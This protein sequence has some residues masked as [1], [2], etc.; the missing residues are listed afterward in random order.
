MNPNRQN[1]FS[2]AVSG[3]DMR[4]SKFPVGFDIKTSFNAGKLVPLDWIEVLPGDT[5]DINGRFVIRGATPLYPV[6]DNAFY[7][8]YAFFVPNRQ[9]DTDWEATFGQNDKDYWTLQDPPPVPQ[10]NFA[11]PGGVVSVGSV[12]DYLGIP[13]TKTS[14]AVANVNAL[15]FRA[16]AKIWNDWFRDENFQNP[17]QITF[18]STSKSAMSNLNGAVDNYYV[19]SASY[20]GMLCPVNKIHDYFTSALPAPQKGEPVSIPLGEFAPV[21]NAGT[22]TNTGVL[23]PT[24]NA[25]YL[26]NSSGEGAGHLGGTLGGIGK[27][28]IPNTPA[29]PGQSAVGSV[30][31]VWGND[32]PSDSPVE[33]YHSLQADLSEAASATINQLR[34][35]FQTQKY[36][37]RLARGGSRYIEYLKSMFGVTSS[38]YRLQRSEYLGGHRFPI[39]QHQVAQTSS[40][41]KEADTPL[42]DT[43]AFSLSNGEG[44]FVHKSFEEHGILMF[45]GCVRTMHT[46]QQGIAREFFRKTAL[47]YYN[48]LFANLGEQP[49]KNAQIYYNPA[50]SL[51]G[52]VPSVNDEVFGYQEAWAEYRY[53]PSRTSGYMR[54]GVTGSLDFWHYGDK[55]DNLPVL[56]SD[57]IS[58]TPKNIDRTLAVS[59]DNTHQFW[60]D[61]YFYGSS[62]RVM[63]VYSIPGLIDHH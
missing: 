56:G 8:I 22:A 32:V 11:G 54:S 23:T 1:R 12:A 31:A 35:A 46:Y 6:M 14:P 3:M 36:F 7:D 16:Y 41:Q 58:E 63:P 40:A 48:P 38:D 28:G 10:L 27:L 18:D 19:Q 51:N 57:F 20:G 44:S 59:S 15:P 26:Y 42:G 60:A 21:V 33:L 37:E 24:K 34:L 29:S 39:N 50:A 4:R 61:M 2:K 49:I 47:D 30:Y 62:M 45:V 52:N 9:I 5:F 13:V 55:Y 43:G 53:H 17:A 25:L